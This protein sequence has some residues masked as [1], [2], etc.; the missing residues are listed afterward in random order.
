MAKNKY[1][2]GQ[3]IICQLL[4]LIPRDLFDQVVAEKGSDR[5]YKTMTT[6]KQFVF[7]FYG[8]VMRC[9]SLK[10]VC[11]NLL[12]LENKLSYLGITQLPAVS[13][14]SDANINRSSEVFACLYG[15]LYEYYKDKLSPFPCSFE[16]KLDIKKVFCF[17]STT[18]TLFVD[19]FKGAGRNSINGK[20][21][22]GLKLH[23]KMPMSGFVPDLIHISEAA[24]NDKTFLGQLNVEN[25]CIYIFD[26]GYV[27]YPV[28]E[29][30]TRQGVFY[31]TRLN[32][33]ASYQ[34]IGGQVNH[35][36]DYANGGIISDQRILL[37]DTLEA[38]LIVFKDHVNGKVLKFISNM[39]DYH[40]TTIIQLYK[41][42]WNIEVLFKQLKQNFELSYFF[43]DSSEGIKTQIWIA[44][45]AQLIFS[46]IHRQIKE[47]EAFVT[48]VNVASNNMGSYISLVRIMKVSQLNAQER[49]L[50]IVQLEIFGQK[51][52]GVF[53]NHEKSP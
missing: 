35:S 11:K 47:N 5:Y 30:W 38:R 50:D 32:E 52:G 44:L 49:N 45:I 6:F 36:V 19:I 12:L 25:G 10:N 24:C 16:D 13:T 29:E 23:T 42:R 37:N 33:N 34:L 27:N 1:I 2:T 39:F 15:K 8:V 26:K 51:Q 40:D 48:L 7:L 43:S 4:S 9:R 21:K 17:D 18:I 22:G 46:V 31:L 14:L 20:K 3:P 53:Q 28:W 41:Y